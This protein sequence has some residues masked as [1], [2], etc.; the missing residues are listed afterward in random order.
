MLGK[1]DTRAI[2]IDTREVL[3][4]IDKIGVVAGVERELT[5]KLKLHFF[6]EYSFTK[7]TDV[8]EK[9]PCCRASGLISRIK[10][11]GTS[12]CSPNSNGVAFPCKPLLGVLELRVI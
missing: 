3:Y 10:N 9:L 2:N 4:E 8:E 11:L 7:T 12:M 6:Y 5:K 1:A